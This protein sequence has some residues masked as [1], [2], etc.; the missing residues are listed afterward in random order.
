M[1]TLTEVERE[2]LKDHNR[3]VWG[4]TAS[5]YAYGFEQLTGEAADAVLDSAGVG[6]ETSLLDVGTGPGTLIAPA[7][8]RGATVNAVDLS[9]EMVA[10]ARARFPRVD[11][12]VAD[13]HALPHEDARFDAVVLGFSMHHIPEPERVLVEA[14]RVLRSGGRIAFSVWAPAQRLELFGLVFE[15]I[16]RHVTDMS[17]PTLQAPAIGDELGDYERLLRE[18]GFEHPSA[19]IVD[20]GWS[21][22]DASLLFEGFDRYFDLSAQ[23]KDVRDAIRLDLDAAV[24]QRADHSGRAVIRNPAVIAAAR[25]P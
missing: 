11:I 8:D 15:V 9:P 1:T 24:R 21:L 13:A 12:R 4:R 10:A 5:V 22:T 23:E 18:A 17:G 16:G 2:A 14:K 25:R 6:H 7:L 20:I 3:V 19:R